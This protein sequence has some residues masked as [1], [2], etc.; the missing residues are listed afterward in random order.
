VDA[1]DSQSEDHDALAPD[2]ERFVEA[3]V[4][5]WIRRGSHLMRRNAVAAP[6]KRAEPDPRGRES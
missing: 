6:L 3:F 1:S 2:E 5:Y 4:D